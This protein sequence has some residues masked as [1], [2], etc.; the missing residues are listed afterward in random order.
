M[1]EIPRAKLLYVYDS[2][3]NIEVDQP[4]RF[5]DLIRDILTR[6]EAFIVYPG[7]ALAGV[8]AQDYKAVAVATK[9]CGLNRRRRSELVTT[10]TLQTLIAAAASIGFRSNPN[11]G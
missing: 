7:D 8:E 11:N 1:R 3:H 6:G 4:E 5:V 9:I 10:K 2:G